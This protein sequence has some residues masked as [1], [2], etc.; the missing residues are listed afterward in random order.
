MSQVALRSARTAAIRARVALK[1]SSSIPFRALS[2]SAVRRSDGHADPAP[3]LY[4]VGAK[5]GEVP[6]DES[7]STGLERIQ[8]LG[9]LDGVEVFDF[10]P[11]DASRLGTMGNPIKVF[12]VVCAFLDINVSSP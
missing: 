1:P 8:I 9:Y 11:L 5:P 2:T 7:Q 12:S 6:T 3:S 4:G 10:N